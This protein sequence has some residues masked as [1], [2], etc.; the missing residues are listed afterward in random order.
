MPMQIGE[1]ELKAWMVQ[2]LAGDAAAHRA[3]LSA[4]APLLRGYFARRMGAG[5]AD[6]EDLVQDTL[7]AIHSRRM[8]YDPDR[9]FTVWAYAI[10]RYKWID[11]LRR[12]RRHVPLEGLEEV[13][14]GA[15]FEAASGARMDI[16]RLLATLP[17]KQAGAIRATRIE[18]LSV[19]EAAA[20]AGLSEPDIK[21][22]VHRGLKSLAARLKG[23]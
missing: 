15:E 2:G 23:R 18:G 13:L 22:S 5:A 3:L 11:S 1:N 7:I 6:V 14:P 17:P 21:V 9:P 10:A 19:A 8:T 4:L 20:A 12:R 16:E